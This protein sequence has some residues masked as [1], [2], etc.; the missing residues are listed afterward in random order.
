MSLCRFVEEM[1]AGLLRFALTGQRERLSF[2]TWK[3]A[4]ESELD[5]EVFR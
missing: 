1:E 3:V 4:S 2:L 5:E